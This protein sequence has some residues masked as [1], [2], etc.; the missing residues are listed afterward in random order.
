MQLNEK[1]EELGEIGVKVLAEDLLRRVAFGRGITPRLA[2]EKIKKTWP[3][4][5]EKLN[6]L[7]PYLDVLYGRDIEYV[8]TFKEMI[9]ALDNHLSD[10]TISDKEL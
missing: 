8:K 10:V 3:V 5:W 4:I 6:S 9:A 1:C 7:I 2:Q